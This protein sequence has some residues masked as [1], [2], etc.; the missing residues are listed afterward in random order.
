MDITSSAG[1]A[2]LVQDPELQKVRVLILCCDLS[3]SFPR[4]L[5]L[6]SVVLFFQLSSSEEPPKRPTSLATIR[7]IAARAHHLRGR[8]RAFVD[9]QG[10]VSSV[11]AANNLKDGRFPSGSAP[12]GV[13]LDLR[14]GAG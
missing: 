1:R 8:A 9:K 4:L 11:R 13:R 10:G 12:E 5:K 2:A 6:K 14:G 7:K 3:L